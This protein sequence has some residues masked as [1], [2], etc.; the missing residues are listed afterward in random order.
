MRN[1]R[2]RIDN[3]VLLGILRGGLLAL[4]VVVLPESEASPCI[5]GVGGGGVYGLGDL[6]RLDKR[7]GHLDVGGLGV[8]CVK[9]VAVAGV[10]R[11]VP[12]LVV[13]LRTAAVDVPDVFLQIIYIGVVRLELAL[14]GAQAGVVVFEVRGVTLVG[15]KVP[16]I[17]RYGGEVFLELVRHHAGVGLRLLAVERPVERVVA[18]GWH[19][20]HVARHRG[21]GVYRRLGHGRGPLL[22]ALAVAVG[23][24]ESGGGG[25]RGLVG[26]RVG[27][28]RGQVDVYLNLVLR[29]A[30]A[31]LH[32]PVERVKPALQRL[33]DHVGQGRA[34]RRAVVVVALLV[35]ELVVGH[36]LVP[37]AG[38]EA[39][40]LAVSVLVKRAERRRLG[41]VAGDRSLAVGGESDAQVVALKLHLLQARELVDARIRG[42]LVVV[43]RHCRCRLAQLGHLGVLGRLVIVGH[44]E[45][46][47]VDARREVGDVGVHLL[48]LDVLPRDVGVAC[49]HCPVR[50]GAAHGEVGGHSGDFVALLAVVAH[51]RMRRAGV[52]HIDVVSRGALRH[53]DLRV[54]GLAVH[55][56]RGR[57][58]VD[59]GAVAEAAH[60]G[61]LGRFV[62]ERAS[63]LD[64]RPAVVPEVDVVVGVRVGILHSLCR[65]LVRDV[66]RLRRS[67]CHALIGGVQMHRLV[68]GAHHLLVAGLDVHHAAEEVDLDLVPRRARHNVALLRAVQLVVLVPAE[69]DGV[70]LVL[71]GGGRLSVDRNVRNLVRYLVQTELLAVGRGG[72]RH[73]AVGGQY[74]L[75]DVLARHDAAGAALV[76]GVGDVNIQYRPRGVLVDLPY[77]LDA[78]VPPVKVGDVSVD[79]PVLGVPLVGGESV[80]ADHGALLVGAEP[81]AALVN[82][83]VRVAAPVRVGP[84]GL[85]D[86]HARI[87][88]AAGEAPPCHLRPAALV[89]GSEV[90]IVGAHPLLLAS[91][92]VARGEPRYLDLVEAR[93]SVLGLGIGVRDRP[94]ELVGDALLA[95]VVR[96]A[97]L[98]VLL[99]AGDRR[100]VARGV[101]EG[102]LV[103]AAAYHAPLTSHAVA[104]AD[105]LDAGAAEVVIVAAEALVRPVGLA[106]VK[107]RAAVH[108]V[109]ARA[110]VADLVVP[111]DDIVGGGADLPAVAVDADLE[112]ELVFGRGQ[113]GDLRGERLGVGYLRA[114]GRQPPAFPSD[115][116]YVVVVLLAE[117]ALEAAVVGTKVLRLARVNIHGEVVNVD[118]DPVLAAVALREE[119]PVHGVAEGV[120]APLETDHVRLGDVGVVVEVLYGEAARDRIGVGERAARSCFGELLYAA[121]HVAVVHHGPLAAGEQV[122]CVDGLVGA[123]VG[124][125][126]VVGVGDEL[127][128]SV[129]GVVVG[130]AEGDLLLV[131]R[132]RA[133]C[134]VV[135]G[136]VGEVAVAAVEAP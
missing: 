116:A 27:I 35:E 75:P 70:E 133:D 57:P 86:V 47:R 67:E 48:V 3:L 120:P 42:E 19:V 106:A 62:R 7:H 11:G 4:L 69:L 40:D 102:D 77:R 32:D 78:V 134:L 109:L 21:R 74:L 100:H 117:V 129:R 132:V 107:G 51:S 59:V 41:E 71:V 1:T 34:A 79:K 104:V 46:K 66:G 99:E 28:R 96:S 50:A 93:A 6:V 22:A 122:V 43:Q 49:L 91:V 45:R 85:V 125:V 103:H 82:N 31:P 39:G 94:P 33:D 15:G 72:H 9:G 111:Q 24:G 126:V 101:A 29:G 105:V 118:V 131:D 38:R 63:A 88:R 119:L 58:P 5:G 90:H 10:R 14:V 26:A 110:Y 60:Y 73:R 89:A 130:G 12:H 54:G 135:V 20:A 112:R 92:G 127:L 2:R 81:Y 25:A 108:V 76:D 87:R 17:V 56:E 113:V 84:L 83:E 55:Y 97:V 95:P 124:V 37:L 53:L 16:L 136:G 68:V 98:D 44:M 123:V 114:R 36:L 13:V 18:A 65:I 80:A 23:G 121:G 64:Y 8:L 52:G 115:A 61:A 30:A 128:T